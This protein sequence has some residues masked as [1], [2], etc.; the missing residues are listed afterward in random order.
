MTVT[1]TGLVIGDNTYALTM[2]GDGL[3]LSSAASAV[4]QI[5]SATVTHG[6]AQVLSVAS[7]SKMSGILSDGEGLTATIDLKDAT[8]DVTDTYTFSGDIALT[9]TYRD[10]DGTLFSERVLSNVDL[11]GYMV[12]N[13]PSSSYDGDKVL[14]AL[15]YQIDTDALDPTNVPTDDDQ[16]G[17]VE[18]STNFYKIDSFNLTLE[19]PVSYLKRTAANDRES[20]DVPTNPESKSS[21]TLRIQGAF[22]RLA[23]ATV[24]SFDLNFTL[25]D[26]NGGVTRL[27]GTVDNGSDVDTYSFSNASDDG[28]TLTLT[29]DETATSGAGFGGNV[30]VDGNQTATISTNGVITITTDGTPFSFQLAAIN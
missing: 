2:V 9:Q 29:Y 28:A 8:I 14:F 19:G 23:P 1:L 21:E 20:T 22:E 12:N 30:T 6:E 13:N 15:S 10:T 5:S 11:D 25:V 27:V 24:R 26:A 16:D 18:S 3:D 7:T 17:G 4:Y